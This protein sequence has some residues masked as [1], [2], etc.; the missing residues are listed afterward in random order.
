MKII[1]EEWQQIAQQIEQNVQQPFS[2]SNIQSVSGGCINSTYILQSE[3]NSYFIKLNQAKFLPMFEA[4]F[5]GLKELRKTKTIRIPQPIVCGIS[6]DKTFLVMEN[7]PLA[8]SSKQSDEQLGQQLAALHQIQQ[9]FFGWHIDNTIGSTP[10]PNS[11]SENWL[12]FW[13]THRLGFQL[14]LAETNGYGGRLLQSGEKLSESL[15]Y[16]FSDYHP[17][18]SLLH[19]DLWSGNAAVSATSNEPVIYDPACYYGDREAD[20]AMTELFDGFGSNFYAAYSTIYPLDSGYSIRKKLY[21]LYHI[22][23]HLNLFGEGYLHQAQGLIDS[24]LS[25]I[26]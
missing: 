11:R 1:S 21:N 13:Q 9:P 20:I 25:E 18:P 24:L 4:E 26:K 7:I 3:N 23:N 5:A 22:L 17:T 14:S 8:S 16:F 2:I 15:G 12:S 6:G 19:G 10:Q